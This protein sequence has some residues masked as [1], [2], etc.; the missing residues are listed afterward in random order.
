MIFQADDE[1]IEITH[2]AGDRSI[3]ARGAVTAA[4]WGSGKAPG[5]Y[6]MIDVLGLKK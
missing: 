3:F 2:K 6:D 1:R 4:L 5:K